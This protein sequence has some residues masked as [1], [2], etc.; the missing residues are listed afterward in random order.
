[1]ELFLVQNS[2]DSYKL[3]WDKIADQ[4][5][6]EVIGQTLYYNMAQ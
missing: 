2:F 3:T 5:G 4:F 6:F 1:V